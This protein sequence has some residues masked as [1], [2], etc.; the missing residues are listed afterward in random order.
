M[1]QIAMKWIENWQWALNEQRVNNGGRGG[2][3]GGGGEE[4]EHRMDPLWLYLRFMSSVIE[5]DAA[6][7]VMFELMAWHIRIASRWC[8][9]RRV[10]RSSLLVT[11]H[12]NIFVPRLRLW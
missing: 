3:G 2:E 10:M 7:F 8:R 12:S 1:M 6:A 9:A 4:Y 5:L 11:E